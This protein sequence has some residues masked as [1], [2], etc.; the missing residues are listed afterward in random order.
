MWK[1]VIVIYGLAGQTDLPDHFTSKEGYATE[2]LCRDA[3]SERVGEFA[4]TVLPSLGHV[5]LAADCS[6]VPG[7]DA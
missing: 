1:I 4:D 3:M 6:Q 7:K 2:A 5:K